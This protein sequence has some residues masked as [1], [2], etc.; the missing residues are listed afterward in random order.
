VKEFLFVF[1]SSWVV[2]GKADPHGPGR[3]HVH[4]DSP[5]IGSAWMKNIISF[6]KL[7]LTNNLLDENGHVRKTKVF[8][9]EK[10]FC[11]FFNERLFL[12]QCIVINLE[13]IVFILHQRKLM[14]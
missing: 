4:P 5:Q 14:N 11:V 1:S 13:F 9:L 2:A 12:I 10:S 3:F 6:D 7:K 8:L